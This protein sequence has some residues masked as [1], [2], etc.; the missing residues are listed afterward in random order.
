MAAVAVARQRAAQV[1]DFRSGNEMAALSAQHIDFHVMGYYPITP[2]TEI[3]E[4][5]DELKAEGAH[6][7]VM[8]PADGEHGAA[9]ICYGA[10][11]GGGRGFKTTREPGLL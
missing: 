7:T 2:S 8:I 1:Q 6:R 5:L 10:A 11:V 3:A 4:L 9:G